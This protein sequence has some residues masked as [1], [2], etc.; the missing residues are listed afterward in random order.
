MTDR[1]KEV[2]PQDMLIER[3]CSAIKKNQHAVAYAL[4][5]FVPKKV[6]RPLPKNWKRAVGV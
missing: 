6:R 2:N 1:D 3:Y 5:T 4:Q